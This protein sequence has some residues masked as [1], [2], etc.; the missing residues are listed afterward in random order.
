MFAFNSAVP[1]FFEQQGYTIYNH[2]YYNLNGHPYINKRV[3]PGLGFRTINEQTLEGRVTN[4]IDALSHR[5]YWQKEDY[6][7]PYYETLLKIE[8]V[9]QLASEGTASP[10]FVL[11]HVLAPH[12][13]F[14]TDST[15]KLKHGS[16]MN[17]DTGAYHYINYLVACNRKI[18]SLIT[19]INHST[20]GE[21]IIILLGDHG[22]RDRRVKS[23]NQENEFM[24]L[25]AIHLPAGANTKLPPINTLVNL[26]PAIFNTSF[27][28]NIPYRRD[29][30]VYIK[31]RKDL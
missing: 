18:D 25:L 29:S 23:P 27:G 30:T 2:S 13:P 15:G 22:Y 14:Y 5:Q 1:Q 3:T 26:F 4:A 6:Y 20:R 10:K 19:S 12:P 11:M 9:K 7:V 17:I 28:T 16:V 8:A 21:A 24:N 31:I